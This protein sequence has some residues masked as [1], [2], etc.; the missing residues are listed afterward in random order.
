M[1]MRLAEVGRDE[2]D[3]YRRRLEAFD[4]SEVRESPGRGRG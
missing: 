2:V 3:A 4:L 1:S